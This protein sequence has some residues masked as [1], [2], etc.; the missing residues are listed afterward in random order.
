MK[1]E[2]LNAEVI[3]EGTIILSPVK[4]L[5]L[6]EGVDLDE[7]MKTYAEV[8]EIDPEAENA[9]EQYQY[10]LKGHKAFVSARN[11][12]EKV[13]KALKAPALEFGKLVDGKAKALKE[14]IADK[15]MALY[16]Q[17]KKVEDNEER[18]MREAEEAERKRQENINTIINTIKNLP[19]LAVGRSAEEIKEIMTGAEKPTEDV[20]EERYK[21]ALAEW[22]KADEALNTMLVQAEA[23][24]VA[25][26]I[27]EEE[28]KRKAE[29]DA[30]REA[31]MRA[32]REA[33]EREKAEFEAEKAR[34]K[35]EKEAKEEA[36]R[37]EALE[38]EAEELMQSPEI[39]PTHE[40]AERDHP[41]VIDNPAMEATVEA[42]DDMVNVM[43]SDVFG[44]MREQAVFIVNAIKRGEI[45]HIRMEV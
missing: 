40:E 38:R 1:D 43:G 36:E 19:L 4:D 39:Y 26:R 14:K 28:D 22:E 27:K 20:C 16:L 37:L 45:R 25:K 32:E 7:L 30:K 17:R 6:T 13:R 34:M 15:E 35:A 18:K 2:T 9:G 8:P 41:L 11:K 10:V 12:I 33:F 3:E 29:E 24:E 42:V 21:E 44:T 23:F 31:E 5:D